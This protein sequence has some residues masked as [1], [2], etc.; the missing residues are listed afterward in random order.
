MFELKN[1]TDVIYGGY[2]GIPTIELGK[3]KI[4]V[5][6]I[7]FPNETTVGICF[8]ANGSGNVGEPI[9]ENELKNTVE[10]NAFLQIIATNPDSLDVLIEKAQ[11]AKRFFD[12][13]QR[14][15]LTGEG[16]S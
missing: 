8:T 7:F 6:S 10:T 3:G 16:E 9:P 13:S 1:E 4:G 12:L 15:I 14:P 2:N 11:E 5:C